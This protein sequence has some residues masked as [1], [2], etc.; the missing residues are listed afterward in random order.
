[1]IDRNEM[2]QEL[3]LRNFI[4]RA[5]KVRAKNK[6]QSHIW[7]EYELRNIIRKLLKEAPTEK[8]QHRSTGIN[9]LEDLL[10]KI[11]PVLEQD[12]KMLT[13]DIEQRKSFSA[14]IVVAAE[15]ALA[16]VMANKEAGAED[17]KFIGISE[18]EDINEIEVEIGEKPEDD[19]AFID[20]DADKKEEEE[21]EGNFENLGDED[22]TGA[23]FAQA[24]FDK[25]EKQII[26]AYSLL[27][28]EED[29]K[30]F[31][32]YL[33]T[34]I[35]LYF[36][37]FENELDPDIIEPTTDEYEEEKGDT[38]GEEELGGEEELEL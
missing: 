4:K 27:S 18:I 32:D 30:L 8:V 17:D 1:M 6:K 13:T 29:Q 38:E 5:I 21:E 12:Y 23:N 9:V 15:N 3:K 33:I 16:P 36:D 7:E 26:D 22:K 31:Y 24:T 2:I 14:H 34:N 37:K 25:I 19:D 28:N 11:V 10:K 35:K 20:I